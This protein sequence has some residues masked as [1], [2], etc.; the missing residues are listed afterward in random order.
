M[1]VSHTQ[2]VFTADDKT[3]TISPT[4]C[5]LTTPNKKFDL[6]YDMLAKTLSAM[7]NDDIKPYHSRDYYLPLISTKMF[8]G[9]TVNISTS[10]LIYVCHLNGNVDHIYSMKDGD[11]YGRFIASTDDEDFMFVMTPKTGHLMV[12]YVNKNLLQPVQQPQMVC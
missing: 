11:I 1:T 5:T 9:V 10:D 2:I 6:D 12:K 7:T 3:V 4:Q 8:P